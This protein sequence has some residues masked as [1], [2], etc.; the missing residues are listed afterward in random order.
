[1]T[2]TVIYSPYFYIIRHVPSGLFY[3]GCRYSSNGCH[4][5]ELLTESGYK[6]SSGTIKKLIKKDGLVSFE[7]I[8]IIQESDIKIPFAWNNI[9]DFETDF[10]ILNNCAKSPLWINTH[11][12]TLLGHSSKKVKQLN[13]LKYG[14]E[15]PIQL[16]EIKS[17]CVATRKVTLDQKIKESEFI[18]K[19]LDLPNWCFPKYSMGGNWTWLSECELEQIYIIGKE[20]FDSR[21]DLHGKDTREI[22]K[23]NSK[24]AMNKNKELRMT[25]RDIV[26]SKLESRE[27]VSKLKSI[28]SW[29]SSGKL[30]KNWIWLDTESLSLLYKEIISIWEQDLE[31]NEKLDRMSKKERRSYRCSKRSM[32]LYDRPIIQSILELKEKQKLKLKAGWWQKT[33]EELELLFKELLFKYPN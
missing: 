14:V 24:K 1:M 13:L 33:T 30:G 19:I 22:N 32:A 3:A 25:N 11:N 12:N 29:F 8:E 17:K 15:Y 28:P 23:I 21:P 2:S 20:L 27:I 4:H 7:I 18:Q 9:L 6:T 26:K 5:S 31:E 16:P 10:L